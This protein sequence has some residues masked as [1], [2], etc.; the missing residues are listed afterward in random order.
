MKQPMLLA[1]RHDTR[2]RGSDCNQV[3][4]YGIAESTSTHRRSPCVHVAYAAG[5]A[6][7]RRHPMNRHHGDYP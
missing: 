4:A 1:E 5:V 2:A 3:I 7:S 6:T